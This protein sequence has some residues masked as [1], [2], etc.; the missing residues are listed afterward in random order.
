[1]TLAEPV[2]DDG[3]GI[4]GRRAHEGLVVAEG[5]V[6]LVAD[7]GH[8][9]LSRQL[10]QFLQLFRRSHSPSRVRRAVAEDDLCTVRN[11]GGHLADVDAEV[12]IRVDHHRHTARQ[13]R[14]VLVHDKVRIEADHFIAGADQRAQRQHQGPAGPTGHED[15]AVTRTVLRVDPCLQLFQQ[16]TNPLRLRVGVV[17]LLN[18]LVQGILDGLGRVKVRLADAEIDGV[19]HAGGE[20]EDLSNP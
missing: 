6:D 9:P 13:P 14:Q 3:L 17:A 20:I 5:L 7:E 12:R 11:C 15:L 10:R 2:D 19:F 1:M 16:R 8:V 18:R 4:P